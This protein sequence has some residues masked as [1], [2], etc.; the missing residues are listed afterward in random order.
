MELE[1][2]AE[3]T[4]ALAAE[5]GIILAVPGHSMAAAAEQEA[6]EMAA[7]LSERLQEAR[8]EQA[9]RLAASRSR[10][11]TEV[12]AHR[13]EHRLVAW[14]EDRLAESEERPVPTDHLPAEAEEEL[15]VRT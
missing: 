12:L 15:S 3:V 8:L 1:D 10:E 11:A 4:G 9:E 6:R 13:L 5:A 2:K 7:M 14:Q